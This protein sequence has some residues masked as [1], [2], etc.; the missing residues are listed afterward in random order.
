MSRPVY[1]SCRGA[2]P[3]GLRRG[4]AVSNTPATGSAAPRVPHRVRTVLIALAA[5]IAAA[6]ASSAAPARAAETGICPNEAAREAQVYG[7][8]LPDCRAYEQVSPVEKSYADALGAI[9]SVRGAPSGEAVTFDSLGPYPLGGGSGEGSPQLFTTYLS[10]RG[11][12]AWATRNVEPAVDPGGLGAALGV[13]EDLRCTFVL[14]NNRP[15]LAAGAGAIEGRQAVYVRDN[16]T[17]AYRMLFQ[18][19]AG[20]AASFSFVAAA[21]GDTRIFFES[22][23]QLLGQAPAGVR[24]LYEWR[25]G[26]L[27]LIDVLH[28]GT[29]AAGGAAGGLGPGAAEEVVELPDHSLGRVS[30]FVQNAVSQDG[31]RVLFTDLGTGRI[32][33]REPQADGAGETLEVSNGPA[34]WQAAT[35][36][37]SQDLYIEG[38]VLY[39]FEVEGAGAGQRVA[40]TPGGGEAQG[41][42]G[43]SREGS[44][45]YF[46]ANGAIAGGV[47]AAVGNIYLW[48]AGVISLVSAGGE[49]DDW[50]TH[51]LLY[52]SEARAGAEEGVRSARVSADGRTLMFTSRAKPTG[53]DNNGAGNDCAEA[54]AAAACDEVYVYN[55]GTG[56]VTCVSC[57]P[58]GTPASS[59]AVLYRLENDGFLAPAQLYPWDLPRNLSEDGSRVFF[60]TEEQL[61]PADSNGVMDVYEWERAGAGSCPAGAAGGCLSLISSGV[62]SE[63]SYFAEA[64]ANGSDLFFFTRQ[65]L[66]GQDED[67]LVDLYDAREGG[68]IAAQSPPA[69]PAPCMGEACLPATAPSPAEGPAASETFAGPGNLV[70]QPAAAPAPAPAARH[71]KRIG[72]HHPR[73]KAKRAHRKQGK[74]RGARAGRAAGSD[75]HEE[76]RR[77]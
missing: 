46:A 63:P 38:G 55:S 56:T 4:E 5:G 61:V 69:P 8:A 45:I 1:R 49:A 16:G 30:Y 66:V 17:G 54:G 25:E 41:V 50:T 48:H 34:A 73:H 65:P 29:A 23:N 15:P 47:G 77:K 72:A 26:Q 60:E 2:A 13:T 20:E 28:G 3:R 58:R 52:A 10:V 27:S 57:N 76:T 42:L 40:L 12:E 35:P 19:G 7:G 32:Y 36:D 59:D 33:L 43:L 14:S 64:S 53:Y 68:G 70:F 37:G 39:R 11:V 22:R 18:A 51:T 9:T 31:S 67:E 6:V 74:K 24:N 44:Y 71:E 21:D 62:S 75:G